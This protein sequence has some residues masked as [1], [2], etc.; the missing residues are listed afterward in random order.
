ML[1]AKAGD[2][3]AFDYL[4]QKYRRPIVSFMY[5]MAR[6]AAAAEDLAQ[7]VFLRVYRS[8]EGYEASAGRRGRLTSHVR[9]SD[10]TSRGVGQPGQCTRA[11]GERVDYEM[12][13]ALLLLI[14]IMVDRRNSSLPPPAGGD[15][16]PLGGLL[17]VAVNCF[18]KIF[19]GLVD[20]L[21]ALAVV[22]A[23]LRERRSTSQQPYSYC[24]NE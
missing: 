21:V 8:R 12:S 5:R 16:S 2:Q 4:V 14:A 17:T 23:R 1:R 19:L 11:R 24:G 7:E 15:V 3:S 13:M 20:T 10:H 6:N 9:R 22:I 18:S